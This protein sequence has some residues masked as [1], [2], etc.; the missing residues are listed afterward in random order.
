[1]KKKDTKLLDKVRHWVVYYHAYWTIYS[2]QVQELARLWEVKEG[3]I[4]YCLSL[5]NKEGL[6][7]RKTNPFGCYPGDGENEWHKYQ[8]C[9]DMAGFKYRR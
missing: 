3:A 4:E 6:I 7:S 1:M 8:K 2:C 9:E 5:L